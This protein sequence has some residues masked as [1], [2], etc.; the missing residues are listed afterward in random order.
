MLPALLRLLHHNDKEVLADA[1]W[2]V[3]Y[4]TDGPN[5]RIEV[6]VQAGLV[7]QLVQLLACSEIAIVVSVVS[8][9]VVPSRGGKPCFL[10]SNGKNLSR[11]HTYCTLVLHNTSSCIL[12]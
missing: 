3:S 10:N 12:T 7:P 2:A 9:C 8:C 11:I 5:E 1:C 4:L 6:V